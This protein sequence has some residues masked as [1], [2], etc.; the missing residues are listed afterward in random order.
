MPP[1]R[2]K[3]PPP[4]RIQTRRTATLLVAESASSVGLSATSSPPPRIQTRHTS[5]LS[6]GESVGTTPRRIQPPRRT[7]ALLV[8]SASSVGLS[9]TSP[10]PQALD[11]LLPP[12]VPDD[13]TKVILSDEVDDQHV[14]THLPFEGK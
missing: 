9:A 2:K 13:I 12:P 8:A 14:T 7:T 5:A 10:P 4:C 1:R 3:D 11:S 6:V